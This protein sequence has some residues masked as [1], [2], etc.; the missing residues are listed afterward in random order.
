MTTAGTVEER[1]GA[2]PG[3]CENPSGC[4]ECGHP[5]AMHSNGRTGCKAFA[6]ATGPSVQCP[7]CG[8]MRQLA[9][10]ES[11]KACRGNGSIRLPC[12]AFAPAVRAA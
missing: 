2:R 9:T 12:Q 5:V 3:E 4:A 8:G 6:C 11:C 1:L 7:G 10:G